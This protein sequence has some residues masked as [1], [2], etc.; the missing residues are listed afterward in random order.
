MKQSIEY[1]EQAGNEFGWAGSFEVGH[2]SRQVGDYDQSGDTSRR[3]SSCSP[4]TT[5]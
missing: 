1:Y 5:T 3:G 2:L 4:N